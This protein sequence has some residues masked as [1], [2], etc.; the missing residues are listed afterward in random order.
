MLAN[1]RITTKEIPNIKEALFE[2]GIVKARTVETTSWLI[3]EIKCSIWGWATSNSQPNW[4]KNQNQEG[5]T[6]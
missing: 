6:S 1:R 5:W 4:A 2:E 3:L